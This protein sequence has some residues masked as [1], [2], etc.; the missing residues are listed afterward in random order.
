MQLVSK[1]Q[2]LIDS[3]TTSKWQGKYRHF[4]NQANNLQLE[5]NNSLIELDF[6]K[7]K[8]HLYGLKVTVDENYWNEF[9]VGLSFRCRH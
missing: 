3:L 4:Y 5:I 6:L 1:P 7:R 9:V 8:L 2:D